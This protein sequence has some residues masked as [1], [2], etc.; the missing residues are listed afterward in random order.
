M[1]GLFDDTFIGAIQ[2][3]FTDY[4]RSQ[5]QRAGLV[6]SI[7][8]NNLIISMKSIQFNFGEIHLDDYPE[9]ILKLTHQVEHLIIQ[10]SKH[11]AELPNQDLKKLYLDMLRE[12]KS[13]IAQKQHKH[14]LTIKTKYQHLNKLVPYSIGDNI[15]REVAIE[16]VE[17]SVPL[18]QHEIKRWDEASTPFFTDDVVGNIKSR[19]SDQ[20]KALKLHS[21]Y[22]NQ[23]TTIKLLQGIEQLKI[24]NKLLRCPL[25]HRKE[26]S[27]LFA[28]LNTIFQSI[29]TSVLSIDSA[30][31]QQQQDDPTQALWRKINQELLDRTNQFLRQLY[32]E[33]INT[34]QT[35]IPQLLSE[36]LQEENIRLSQAQFY[37][38]LACLLYFFV[39]FRRVLSGLG[40]LN[41]CY[42]FLCCFC[43]DVK[44][45]ICGT[46]HSI[47]YEGDSPWDAQN[48]TDFVENRIVNSDE[49]LDCCCTLTRFG[50]FTPYNTALALRQ[51]A[52]N[53]KTNPINLIQ[54]QPVTLEESRQSLDLFFQQSSLT[55]ISL[56]GGT[57][58]QPSAPPRQHMTFGNTTS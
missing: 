48:F 37:D 43:D 24:N 1:L 49:P 26:I 53:I 51:K 44:D 7:Y 17:G 21:D 32:E 36:R 57:T 22:L 5:G 40:I 27:Q 50:L 52:T 56:Y 35:S 2:Q 54:A 45:Y 8:F 47:C 18:D 30:E 12:I 41:I 38:R 33:I 4:T 46:D 42:T 14:F 11:I 39:P 28:K 23:N 20:A 10:I 9:A 13:Y 6:D 34:H 55:Q 29:D 19:L 16:P 25:S 15:M 31:G 58:C 3:S